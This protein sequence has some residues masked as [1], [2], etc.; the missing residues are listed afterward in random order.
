MQSVLDLRRFGSS[1]ASSEYCRLPVAP[2][3]KHRTRHRCRYWCSNRQHR[4]RHRNRHGGWC[5]CWTCPLPTVREQLQRRLTSQLGEPFHS[6]VERH[7]TSSCSRLA[8]AAL[9]RAAEG[10]VPAGV[11]YVL[12]VRFASRL[13]RVFLW[14]VSLRNPAAGE[15]Q[16]LYDSTQN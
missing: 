2:C 16:P 13:R 9:R 4:C 6:W 5:C 7:P 8:S 14:V 1:L 11:I 10:P 12:F 15:A 3:T